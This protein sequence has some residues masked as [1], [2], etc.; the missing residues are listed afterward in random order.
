MCCICT[1]GA[2]ACRTPQSAQN[3]GKPTKPATDL[4]ISLLFSPF[5]YDYLV[6]N[7]EFKELKTVGDKTTYGRFATYITYPDANKHKP[8]EK[9]PDIDL[10]ILIDVATEDYSVAACII[11]YNRML[12][13]LSRAISTIK[14]YVYKKYLEGGQGTVHFYFGAYDPLEPV[15][16]ALADLLG[17]KNPRKEYQDFVDSVKKNCWFATLQG[18]MK[19]LH[20]TPMVE[21]TVVFLGKVECVEQDSEATINRK[22][23]DDIDKIMDE[24]H[25]EQYFHDANKTINPFDTSEEYIEKWKKK[26]RIVEKNSKTY[27]VYDGYTI[28]RKKV[29]DGLL[30]WHWDF[31]KGNIPKGGKPNY[32]E[33]APTDDDVEF[34][35]YPLEGRLCTYSDFREW[36][37]ELDRADPTPKMW[38]PNNPPKAPSKS[39]AQQ[40]DE[41]IERL[42][43]E[44]A[45]WMRN[46]YNPQL[47]A[48]NDAIN[49]IDNRNNKNS[50]EYKV[51]KRK[52]DEDESISNEW[53]V[54][55][56]KTEFRGKQVSR[57]ELV[58]RKEKLE[59]EE[60][61]KQEAIDNAKSQKWWLT[62]FEFLAVFQMI[63]G[64]ASFGV[65][66]S[67]GWTI[68]LAAA[69]IALEI[70]KMVV[71][72]TVFN[73]EFTLSNM[74]QHW[75]SIALDGLTIAFSV[76][77]LIPKSVKMA[78]P[79][80]EVNAA[81]KSK[82]KILRQDAPT[83]SYSNYKAVPNSKPTSM[84]PPKQELV[85][86]PEYKPMTAAKYTHQG[87]EATV[88]GVSHN[89][90][91][92]L[93]LGKKADRA[94]N[95]GA[96][97]MEVNWEN[98]T[99]GQYMYVATKNKNGKMSVE[100]MSAKEFKQRTGIDPSELN[101]N[102][103]AKKARQ[104]AID[105][106]IQIEQQN[107][108]AAAQAQNKDAL[109]SL[110][111]NAV[112]T[113]E[114]VGDTSLKDMAAPPKQQV[115]SGEKSAAKGERQGL[116]KD[117]ESIKENSLG[118]IGQKDKKLT[119]GVFKKHFK[120]SVEDASFV[121]TVYGVSS[122]LTALNSNTTGWS[123]VNV[124]AIYGL[125]TT[126]SDFF[127][128]LQK[129]EK[130]DLPEQNV[131]AYLP[132]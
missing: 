86:V 96:N 128:G 118:N 107:A 65:G 132:K 61:K 66:A 104:A 29:E 90:N 20:W 14:D 89:K 54:N 114:E 95:K 116:L 17:Q 9:V 47:K 97:T 81:S 60:R 1:T 106:N 127:E 82:P 84:P 11:S 25:S 5:T 23:R 102:T 113:A 121:W 24:M 39:P 32:P 77:K 124:N 38:G 30:S 42:E 33:G 62:A 112:T 28:I 80:N 10:P 87:K 63:L 51:W 46:T 117:I 6:E 72:C 68:A 70:T 59:A 21:S 105:Q 19:K 103:K 119:S 98:E 92:A 122:N 13:V 56:N 22:R 8:I 130:K 43:N 36:R 50:N 73:Q 115:T 94:N 12:G 71:E 2:G 125:K 40:M 57:S 99:G 37:N 123:L 78:I 75:V 93:N 52:K 120:K 91:E 109:A 74:W 85:P 16:F 45:E 69:D 18:W 27:R 126:Q 44:K 108:A 100:H 131:V 129:L 58:A 41:Y 101:K 15:L 76:A 79:P 35:A 31:R 3:V 49:D 4:H 111:D 110:R 67:I 88:L 26:Y 53:D 48:Y 55:I 7:S 34:I 83:F 64:I